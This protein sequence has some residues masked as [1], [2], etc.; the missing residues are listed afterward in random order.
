MLRGSRTKDRY[1]PDISGAE[2]GSASELAATTFRANR[3]GQSSRPGPTGFCPVFSA[4]LAWAP[5]LELQFSS[6]AC[7]APLPT[8]GGSR[9]GGGGGGGGGGGDDAAGGGGGGG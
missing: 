7:T 8:R 2:G 3:F 5:V 9:A 6:A 4:G 1:W